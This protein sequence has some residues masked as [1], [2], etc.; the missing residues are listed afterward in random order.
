MA[1]VERQK[2]QQWAAQLGAGLCLPQK[3]TSKWDLG[4]LGGPGAVVSGGWS[5]GV[6]SW[7]L[8]MLRLEQIIMTE[9]GPRSQYEEG[10]NG[11]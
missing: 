11:M 2:G 1:N 7:E 10:W 8:S 6:W 3:S 4:R 9:N 5:R